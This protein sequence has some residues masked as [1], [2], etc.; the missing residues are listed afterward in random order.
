M[1]CIL[2]LLLSGCGKSAD[3]A[4]NNQETSNKPNAFVGEWEITNI[5]LKTLGEN[6]DTSVTLHM[7]II[8]QLFPEA[9]KKVDFLDSKIG[10]AGQFIS[11]A[12][13]GVYQILTDKIASINTVACNF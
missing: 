7:R 8:T 9:G 3:N 1:L 10:T 13:T 6:A 11:G 4:S 12:T 2:C 5:D